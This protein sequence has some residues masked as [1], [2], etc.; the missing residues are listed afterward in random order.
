MIIFAISLEPEPDQ[1]LLP[2]PPK[3]I[4]SDPGDPDPQHWS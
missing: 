1:M 3:Q 2:D 4:I